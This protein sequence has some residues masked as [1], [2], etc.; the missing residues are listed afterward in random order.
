MTTVTSEFVAEIINKFEMSDE[1]K[2]KGVLGIDGNFHI[3]IFPNFL[4]FPFV[5]PWIYFFCGPLVFIMVYHKCTSVFLL[6][7]MW[8]FLQIFMQ[9]SLFLGTGLP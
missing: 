6:F 3:F 8:S 5:K 9:W 2:Q 4:I 1:N 7:I